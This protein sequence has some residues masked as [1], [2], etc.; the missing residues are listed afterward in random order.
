M[1]I[2][3]YSLHTLF[4]SVPSGFIEIEDSNLLFNLNTRQDLEELKDFS[5]FS[6]EPS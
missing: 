3:D 2:K 1:K 5:G 4:E 6:K